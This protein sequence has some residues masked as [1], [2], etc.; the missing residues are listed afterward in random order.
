[1]C[2]SAKAAVEHAVKD[3]EFESYTQIAAGLADAKNYLLPQSVFHFSELSTERTL[4]HVYHPEGQCHIST[5]T[6]RE[7]C[8]CGTLSPKTVQR[9]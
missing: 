5:M 2:Y 3:A 8:G 1:V 7:V 6:M 9:A 4:A